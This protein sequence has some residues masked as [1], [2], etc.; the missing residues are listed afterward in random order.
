MNG[1]WISSYSG[2]NN[3]NLIVNI[4]ERPGYYQGV[5]YINQVSKGPSVGAAAL[6]RTTDKSNPFEFRTGLVAPVDPRSGIPVL[7]EIFMQQYGSDLQLAMYADVTGNWD[8]QS[9]RLAWNADDGTSGEAQLPR[10]KASSESA[11]IPL[12]ME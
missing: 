12:R 10:S 3:G 11:L 1:Q 2:T 5:A 4:D 8:D 6:F 7:R 9:L